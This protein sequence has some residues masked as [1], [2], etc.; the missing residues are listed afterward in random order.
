[1]LITSF[2]HLKLGP[3]AFHRLVRPTSSV[4]LVNEEL[5]PCEFQGRRREAAEREAMQR[6]R[7]AASAT[8]ERRSAEARTAVRRRTGSQDRLPLMWGGRVGYANHR[9]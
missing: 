6:Q 1:M 7:L 8:V 4:V 5:R 3:D 2:D 9:R